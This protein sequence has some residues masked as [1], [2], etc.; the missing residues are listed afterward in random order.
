M[1]MHCPL[2][3]R[4][5]ILREYDRPLSREGHILTASPTRSQRPAKLTHTH[6]PPWKTASNTANALADAAA[7]KCA[8]FH[9]KRRGN[10]APGHSCLMTECFGERAYRMLPPASWGLHIPGPEEAPEKDAQSPIPR[11]SRSDQPCRPES[12]SQAT[13]RLGREGGS[14]ALEHRQGA[15]R[16]VRRS[17]YKLHK[18][19]VWEAQAPRDPLTCFDMHKVHV[20]TCQNCNR[21]AIVL[22]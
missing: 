18:G 1:V 13:P 14:S 12:R 8:A 6:W 21:P 22:I 19:G 16:E 5:R 15:A 20:S 11:V 2:A 7:R 4:G 10:A 9:P 17:S 3:A